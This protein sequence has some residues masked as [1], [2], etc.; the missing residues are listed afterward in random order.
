MF[1]D[2]KNTIKIN[3]ALSVRTY[4]PETILLTAKISQND[5]DHNIIFTNYVS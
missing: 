1:D 5:I 3:L 4:L 2:N